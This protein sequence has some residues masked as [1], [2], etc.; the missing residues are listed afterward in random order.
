M[1]EAFPFLA[2]ALEAGEQGERYLKLIPPNDPS[3]V[4]HGMIQFDTRAVG[5]F[6]E[7]SFYLDDQM[8]LTKR[9]PPFAVSLNLGSVPGLHRVRVSGF[10]DGHQVATDELSVNQGGQR[11]RV[12]LTEPRPDVTY[13]NS[14]RAVAH[15]QV[16]DA[17]ALDR[18]ELYLNEQR[19]ATLFQEPFISSFELDSLDFSIVRAVAYLTDG[20]QAEN[21]AFVNGPEFTEELNVQY[22]QVFAG[23]VDGENRAFK[24]WR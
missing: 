11:F 3:G 24:T 20:S 17:S 8:V 1:I 19:M 13:T 9:K 15:V 5:D 14:A 10:V 18:V 12:R 22:V 4:Q 2:E 7:V 6:E 16:P 21:V 23:I